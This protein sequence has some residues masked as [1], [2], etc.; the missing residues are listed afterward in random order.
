M[1]IM[2]KLELVAE[3]SH[4]KVGDIQEALTGF[5]PSQVGDMGWAWGI[6]Y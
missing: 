6:K 2:M 4:S 1:L 3:E 5:L